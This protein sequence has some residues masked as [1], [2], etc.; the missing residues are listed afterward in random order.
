MGG[1]ARAAKLSSEQKA[2]IAKKGAE[3]R[4]NAITIKSKENKALVTARRS[5]PITPGQMSIA[6]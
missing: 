4:W 2:L 3:A 5:N 1:L 6:P